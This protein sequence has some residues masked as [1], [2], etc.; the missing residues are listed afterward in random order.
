MRT[1]RNRNTNQAVYR[2]REFQFFPSHALLIHSSDNQLP[3][4]EIPL[5]FW[6]AIGLLR[7]S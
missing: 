7:E 6:Q 5:I 1:R 4:I 2:K 3:P